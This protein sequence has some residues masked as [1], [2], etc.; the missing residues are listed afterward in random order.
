MLAKLT[1]GFTLI[2]LMI[3]IAIVGILAAIAVPSYI[4]YTNRARFSETV[5]ATASLKAAVGTCIQTLGTVTGCTNGRNG[6]PAAT[7]AVGNLTS[8][9]VTNGVITGTGTAGGSSYTYIIN[10]TYTAGTVTWAVDS[11]SS[12]LAA[13]LCNS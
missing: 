13:G 1:K 12:C 4:G 9:S 3:T 2:E 6:I 8:V 10:P 5:Q 7:G 11:G